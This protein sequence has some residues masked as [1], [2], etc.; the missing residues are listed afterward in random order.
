MWLAEKGI[1]RSE[2]KLSHC[3]VPSN[4]GL[5]RKTFNLEM[6]SSILPGM[7]KLKA[8]SANII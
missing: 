3:I 1:Q 7:T 4:N 2:A 5:V 6:V 8:V